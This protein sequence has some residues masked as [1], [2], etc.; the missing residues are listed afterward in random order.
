MA[1]GYVK[2]LL[3]I[4]INKL[5]PAT[6][7]PTPL[8]VLDTRANLCRRST[9]PRRRPHLRLVAACLQLG[10]RRPLTA[11]Y[12]PLAPSHSTSWSRVDAGTG[13]STRRLAA[14]GV[15]LCRLSLAA[16]LVGVTPRL[17]P[18]PRLDGVASVASSTTSEQGTLVS[19]PP[20]WA[21][22][23]STRPPPRRA[24]AQFIAFRQ[25]R[26]HTR[27]IEIAAPAAHLPTWSGP[28]GSCASMQPTRRSCAAWRCV[29]GVAVIGAGRASP[30][31]HLLAR[32]DRLSV[33]VSSSPSPPPPAP[34]LPVEHTDRSSALGVSQTGRQWRTTRR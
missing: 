8:R 14:P 32:P 27:F 34:P 5:E 3:P 25:A 7:G 18:L 30:S 6:C 20:S 22:D 19:S 23:L 10:C 16:G 9:A 17:I 21:H 24:A 11:W 15:R 4:Y 2:F 31:C 1:C 13:N 12:L 26:A 33:H 29:G 28:L